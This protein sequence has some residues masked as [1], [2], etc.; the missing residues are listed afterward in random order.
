MEDETDIR[1]FPPLRSAWGRRGDPVTVKISGSNAKAVIFGAINI[2]TGHRLFLVHAGQRAEDF[3][4]Y[5][6]Y[7][8]RHYRGWNV[9]MILDGD[10]S[11]TAAASRNAARHLGIKLVWLP[12]RSPELNPMETLWRAAKVWCKLNTPHGER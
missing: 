6:H 1:L 4:I 10:S 5:L 9:M 11:H 2:K 12:V 7:I 8:R 3:Q